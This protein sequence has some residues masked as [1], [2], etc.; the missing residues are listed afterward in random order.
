[1]THEE[2]LLL[3]SLT[4]PYTEVQTQNDLT[5]GRVQALGGKQSSQLAQS[6]EPSC[7]VIHPLEKL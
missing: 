2:V 7:T 1:M 5:L 3:S 6:F 4:K